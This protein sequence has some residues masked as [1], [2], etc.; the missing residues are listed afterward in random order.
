MKNLLSLDPR[1]KLAF[2]PSM[3]TMVRLINQASILFLLTS[4][5]CLL[6]HLK[7]HCELPIF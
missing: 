4:S 2:D 7:E 5:V 3:E 1:E 6:G